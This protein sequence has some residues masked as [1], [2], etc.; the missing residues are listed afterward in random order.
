MRNEFHLSPMDHSIR[1]YPL[2]LERTLDF[3][4]VFPLP[5]GYR[6]SF[7]APGDEA[8]WIRIE[9]SAGEFSAFEEGM[10]AWN[11]YFAPWKELLSKRMVFIETPEGR[12]CAVG[13]AWFNTHTGDLSDGRMHWIAIEKESQGAHLAK[14]LI[15]K[16]LQVM[17]ENGYEKIQV[18][19]KTNAW[20]ASRIYLDFGFVPEKENLRKEKD[21]WK[22]LRRLTDHPS[23]AGIEPAEEDELFIE[24]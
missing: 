8:E 22:I 19:T 10:Q 1:F 2:L 5:E 15:A 14:P 7:Y 3:I 21:G 24:S 6:F 20:L 9:Q 13:S 23:L 16:I 18:S 4:P 12:K 17:K 11:S